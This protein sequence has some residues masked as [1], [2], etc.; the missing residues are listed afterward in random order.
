MLGRGKLG[1]P[2]GLRDVR[3]DRPVVCAR[4]WLVWAARVRVG[5]LGLGVPGSLVGEPFSG[6]GLP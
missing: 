2:V 5:R 6:A 3:D 4:A 1:R